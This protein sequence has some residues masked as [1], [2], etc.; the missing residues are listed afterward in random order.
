MKSLNRTCSSLRLAIVT[1]WQLVQYCAS[2]LS[3]LLEQLWIAIGW[4]FFL[5]TFLNLEWNRRLVTTSVVKLQKATLGPRRQSGPGLESLACLWTNPHASVLVFWSRKFS[6]QFLQEAFVWF[7]LFNSLFSLSSCVEFWKT[8]RVLFETRLPPVP[9][10]PH[11]LG[12]DKEPSKMRLGGV[13]VL[14]CIVLLVC[15]GRG[16]FPG[17]HPPFNL[18]L[19]QL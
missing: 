16:S 4:F 2:C 7:H 13:A 19:W 10:Y 8:S 15:S 17:S 11:S 18:A 1:L 12:S 6:N 14:I 3:F 5:L 9:L